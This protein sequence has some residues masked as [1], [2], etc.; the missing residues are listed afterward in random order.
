VVEAEGDLTG[1]PQVLEARQENGGWR[2]SLETGADPQLVLKA[3]VA[4]PGVKVERFELAEPSLDDI[5]VTVVTGD[6]GRAPAG[7]RTQ[8]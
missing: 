3:I 5:F 6:T 2:L 8:A 4:R 1:L 7:A